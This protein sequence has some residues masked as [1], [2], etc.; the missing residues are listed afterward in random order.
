VGR[1]CRPAD[2]G[3]TRGP[4]LLDELLGARDPSAFASSQS[5]A[6]RSEKSHNRG[7]IGALSRRPDRL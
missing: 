7:A 3:A 6:W 4:D 1:S 2:A 5:T